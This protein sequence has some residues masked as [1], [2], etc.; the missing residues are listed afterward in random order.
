MLV[1][2][3]SL[4]KDCI[5]KKFTSYQRGKAQDSIKKKTGKREN[6]VGTE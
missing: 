5:K 4:L 3:G 1:L 6:D 2:E